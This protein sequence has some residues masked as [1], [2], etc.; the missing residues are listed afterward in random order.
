MESIETQRTKRNSVI[1]I[2][3]EKK[4]CLNVIQLLKDSSL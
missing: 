1:K 4:L 2:T 3:T